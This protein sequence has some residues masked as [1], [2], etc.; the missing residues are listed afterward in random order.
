MDQNSTTRLYAAMGVAGQAGCL[1]VFFAVGALVVGVWLDQVF[2]TRHILVLVC[3][4]VSVPI[5]LVITLRL[6][7]RLIARVIPPEKPRGSQPSRMLPPDDD[8][9]Q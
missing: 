6:T 4:A 3:V 2:G 1:T 7:Q 5:N 9:D 8:N